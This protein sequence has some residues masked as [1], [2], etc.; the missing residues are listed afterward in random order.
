MLLPAI[1]AR[2][3][4]I[5]ARDLEPPPSLGRIGPRPVP[6]PSTR[7]Y[8]DSAPNLL[9]RVCA[10]LSLEPAFALSGQVDPRPLL[11]GK[12][13]SAPGT[14]AHP[15]RAFAL[16]QAFALRHHRVLGVARRQEP[17]P[18]DRPALESSTR[19]YEGPAGD[20]RHPVLAAGEDRH[21]CPEA[22]E[23]L[24]QL[25]KAPGLAA[26]VRFGQQVAET[27]LHHF[28]RPDPEQCPA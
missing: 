27:A 15:L 3:R 28:C 20:C 23:D 26:L 7:T 17:G 19:E 21:G 9:R 11:A 13:I 24:G 6:T 1:A 5:L 4:T 14:V 2:A 8:P 18:E 10:V 16:T 25:V 12:V 22:R